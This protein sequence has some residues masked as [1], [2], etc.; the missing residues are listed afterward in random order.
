MS[1]HYSESHNGK[2]VMSYDYNTSYGG[3]DVESYDNNDDD[4]ELEY[5]EEEDDETAYGEAA[6][7]HDDAG[8][9][10]TQYEAPETGGELPAAAARGD[11]GTLGEMVCSSTGF[12]TCDYSHEQADIAAGTAGTTLRYV[13]RDCGPGTACRPFNSAILCDWPQH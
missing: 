6:P 8:Y 9:E 1:Y 12:N 2:P 10:D 13:Y 11:C 7:A 3:G 5:C 4:D